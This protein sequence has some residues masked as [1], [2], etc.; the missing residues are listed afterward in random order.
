MTT[1]VIRFLGPAAPLPVLS[2]RPSKPEMPDSSGEN[3]NLCRGK[4]GSGI[5]LVFTYLSLV[6]FSGCSQPREEEFQESGRL[7][8]FP[9]TPQGSAGFPLQV[10]DASG[11]RVTFQTP[12]EKIICLVPAL[13]EVLQALGVQDRL[14]ARTDFDTSV[15]LAHLPSVGGG[16]APNLEGLVAQDP[17]LVIM[18][19]GESDSRTSKRLA[20][21]GVPHFS[22]RLDRIADVVAAVRDL[23]AIMGVPHQG[24]SLAA[25]MDASLNEV[26]RAVAGLDRV[27]V[28]YILGGTPPWVAGPETY[29]DELLSIAGADNAFADL[30]AQYGP[31]GPEEFRVRE[32][33]VLVMAEGAGTGMEFPDIP[34]TRVPADVEIPGPHLAQA[35]RQLAKIFHPEAF[36]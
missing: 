27:R 5:L 25:R 21:L 36:R 11:A 33:D 18:F 2:S 3:R 24:D 8:D 17:D 12:P 15:P 35:A 6:S 29:I 23:A 9:G 7:Q 34:L 20:A 13:T 19:E 22:V 30:E 4:R 14:V 31:V 16:L 26:R 32:I 10:V 1:L 28:A